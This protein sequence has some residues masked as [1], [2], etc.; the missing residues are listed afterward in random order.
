VKFLSDSNEAIE[1]WSESDVEKWLDEKKIHRVICEN[2]K[3]SDGKILSQL[4]L[5]QNSAP[6]F[7]YSSISSNDKKLATREVALFAY[8]L[9]KLFAKNL[10]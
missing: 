1:N 5:M 2:V 7:F 3:P 8:E 4:Y 10:F 6:E 9:K